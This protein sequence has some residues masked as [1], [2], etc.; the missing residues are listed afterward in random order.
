M[1]EVENEDMEEWCIRHSRSKMEKKGDVGVE[2]ETE[3]EEGEQMESFFCKIHEFLCRR[4]HLC[5]FYRYLYL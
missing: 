4:L 1:E 5:R 3:K 2:N